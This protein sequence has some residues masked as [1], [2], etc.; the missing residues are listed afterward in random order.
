M[1]YMHIPLSAL[2]EHIINQYNLIEK[3]LNGYVYVDIRQS[4]Y[5]LTQ[6]DVLAKKA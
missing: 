4:I 5:G 1:E 3:A 6:T 2:P